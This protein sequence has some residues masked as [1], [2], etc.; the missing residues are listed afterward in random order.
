MDP[1]HDQDDADIGVVDTA[2]TSASDGG[3][4]DEEPASYATTTHSFTDGL[5]EVGKGFLD[6]GS[7]LADAGDRALYGIGAVEHAAWDSLEAAADALMG[8]REGALRNMDEADQATNDADEAFHQVGKDL[9][10]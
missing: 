4:G 10:F 8:D 2:I 9:G 5:G 6:M 7:S 1:D 3:A